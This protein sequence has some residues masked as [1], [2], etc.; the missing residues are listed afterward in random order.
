MVQSYERRGK[1]YALGDSLEL[2]AFLGNRGLDCLIR[3]HILRAGDY[4]LARL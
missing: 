1:S 3:G 4:D 2:K